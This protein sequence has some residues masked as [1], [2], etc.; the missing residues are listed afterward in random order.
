VGALDLS[1]SVS[2]PELVLLMSGDAECSCG[3]E[4]LELWKAVSIP[5]ARVGVFES[6]LKVLEAGEL[7]A[8]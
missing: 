7:Q 2:E 4:T 3:V 8:K 1:V 6:V 5:K